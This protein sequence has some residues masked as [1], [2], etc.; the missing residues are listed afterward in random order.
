MVIN[1][2]YQS[3]SSNKHNI[4]IRIY[5]NISV[6][7][8]LFSCMRNLNTKESGLGEYGEFYHVK[9]FIGRENLL[10]VVTSSV[11]YMYLY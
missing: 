9:H 10:L 1:L 4:Y 6:A 11:L 8:R 3:T 5:V 2:Q 7:P